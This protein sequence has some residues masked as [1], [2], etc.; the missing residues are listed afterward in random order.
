MQ[1]CRQDDVRT[2]VSGCL[3]GAYVFATTLR[4]NLLLARPDATDQQVG[5]AALAAGL[6][7]WVDEL[8]LGWQTPAGEAGA[9]VSGGQ[10]QRLCLARALLQDPRVLLLDEPTAG[11]DRRLADQV[12]ADLLAATRG[13]TLLLVTHRLAGLDEV[14]EVVVL[15]AG[16]VVQRGSAAALRAQPGMFRRMEQAERDADAQT[17]P[18]WMPAAGSTAVAQHVRA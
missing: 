12:T 13:R 10:A 2:A 18:S 14:D 5:Q 9:M 3:Q 8:P 4:D 16:R 15:A 17:E 1:A 6:A 7:D 11:L